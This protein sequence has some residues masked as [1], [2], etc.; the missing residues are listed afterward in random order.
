MAQA[1]QENESYWLKL[2]PISTKLLS[3]SAAEATKLRAGAEAEARRTMGMAEA[4]A[5]RAKGLAEAQV[6]A[7]QR[8]SRSRSYV[9]ESRSAQTKY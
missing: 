8:S 9:Q 1:E 2:M 4:E 6:T 5:S 7:G 3:R